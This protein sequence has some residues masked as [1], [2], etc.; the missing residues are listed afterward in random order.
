MQQ[1]TLVSNAKFNIDKT[2]AFSLNGKLDSSWN[3]ILT[4]HNIPTYHH[5]RS[6]QAFRYLGFY[7]PY[8]TRQR[9]VLE[10]QLLVK[11]TTQC[12]IYSQRQLSILGRVTIMN[13]LILSKIWYSLRLLKPTKRLFQRLRSCIYQF[14]WQK[15]EPFS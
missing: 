3:S 6:V 2:E 4:E 10:D 5:S 1:Y 12:Q 11:V 13:V 9:R 7:L 8:C 14:I 15:K